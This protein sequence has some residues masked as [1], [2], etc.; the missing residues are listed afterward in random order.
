[1]TRNWFIQL[2]AVALAATMIFSVAGMRAQVTPAAV[3]V[4]NDSIGGVVT[5]LAGRRP[6]FG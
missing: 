2:A 5:G 1:M 6:A 4:D 3:S